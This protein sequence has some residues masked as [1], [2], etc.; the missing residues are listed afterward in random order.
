MKEDIIERKRDMIERISS[1]GRKI[2]WDES[3]I[4]MKEIEDEFLLVGSLNEDEDRTL[5]FK[6]L[7]EK[8]DFHARLK[9]YR[10]NKRKAAI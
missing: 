9:V 3:V 6:F 8:K 10:K 7:K 2:G 1:F 4:Q 5:F